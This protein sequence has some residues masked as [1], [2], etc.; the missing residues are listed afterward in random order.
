MVQRQR[1]T[2]YMVVILGHRD[3]MVIPPDTVPRTN[4][5]SLNVVLITHIADL[6][7]CQKDCPPGITQLS[8]GCPG[9]MQLSEGLAS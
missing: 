4:Q 1:F 8:K 2:V 7:S 5:P 3:N 6:R 9:I